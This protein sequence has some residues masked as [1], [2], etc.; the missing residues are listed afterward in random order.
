LHKTDISR[1][2][3]HGGE[4]VGLATRHAITAEALA[5]SG[6]RVVLTEAAALQKVADSIG[7][8]FV[9]AV[10]LLASVRGRVVVTG[11]GKS[12]HV[13]RKIAATFASTG[14]PAMFVHPAEA[15]HGDLGMI[16]RDDAVLALSNSGETSEL[17]DITLYTRRFD[18]PLIAMVGRPHSTLVDTAD[19]ALVLPA[20][21]EACPMGL[22]PTTST[23]CMLA[24]GDAL[25]VALLERSGFTARD[26]AE[27]H[28]GGKLGS[29][30]LRVEQLMHQGD[31]LPVVTVDCPMTDAVLEMT[32]KRLGCTGVV[33]RDGK[34]VG[35]ITDGDLRRHMMND[36]LE[37]R[38]GEVMTLSPRTIERRAL[39]VEALAL[40]NGGPRPVTILFIVDEGRPIGALHLHDCLR[41]GIA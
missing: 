11:M 41:A 33:D 37:R 23:T 17:R 4:A 31:E 1:N 40:M 32:H 20:V 9:E 30:L 16:T 3:A 36:L 25:A 22:A 26:F 10:E 18:I 2:G 27:F 6:R 39:A 13:A 35:I 29:Q 8:A 34:L 24:L 28:P 15:S 19:V 12:G 5:E 7:T 14:T 38:A 21:G